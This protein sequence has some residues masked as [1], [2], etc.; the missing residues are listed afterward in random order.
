MGSSVEFIWAQLIH[1]S[2]TGTCRTDDVIVSP[3]CL[4]ASLRQNLRS[5]PTGTAVPLLQLLALCFG[6]LL[7][8]STGLDHYEAKKNRICQGLE[9]PLVIFY[10]PRSQ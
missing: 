3:S 8:L 1:I 7:A 5:Q 6:K 10:H 4:S 9:N 2:K